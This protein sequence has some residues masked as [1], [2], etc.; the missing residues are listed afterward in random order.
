[1]FINNSFNNLA[2]TLLD[3]NNLVK[4]VVDSKQETNI[5]HMLNCLRYGELHGVI[6][7]TISTLE[8]TKKSFKSKELAKLREQLINLLQKSV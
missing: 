4:N 7:D 2:G 3:L 8:R 6:K 1:M 5:Y